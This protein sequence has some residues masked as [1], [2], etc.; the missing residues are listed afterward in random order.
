M[1]IFVT[2]KCPKTSAFNLDAR[3]RNKMIVETQQM[4]ATALHKRGWTSCLPFK[5]DGG[6]YKPTHPNHPCTIW[7][8]ESHDNFIW[9]L[10]HLNWLY[11]FYINFD[12]GKG[13]QNVLGN[14]DHMA[15]AIPLF[16]NNELCLTPFPNC[17]KNKSLGI[18]YTHLPVPESYKQYLKARNA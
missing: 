2:S 11:C 16:R 3:R 13:H 18:D 7:V 1:N 4:L 15:K 5:K 9:T 6:V 8:G 10:R 14:I 12:K 17:A